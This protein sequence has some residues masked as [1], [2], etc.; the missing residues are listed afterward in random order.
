M[1]EGA[2]LLLLSEELVE[3]ARDSTDELP[4]SLR[5]AVKRGSDNVLI[6]AI[7]SANSC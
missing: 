5:L 4:D 3:L 2:E 1:E 7:A 6:L